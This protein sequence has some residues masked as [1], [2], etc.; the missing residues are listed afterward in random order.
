MIQ[1][2]VRWL[3][4]Q[5]I[6]E[7]EGHCEQGLNSSTQLI[8]QIYPRFRVLS[9]QHFNNGII[10]LFSLLLA[11]LKEAGLFSIFPNTRIKVTQPVVYLKTKLMCLHLCEVMT[12]CYSV[13]YNHLEMQCQVGNW[14][15]SKNV[16]LLESNANSTHYSTI[17]EKRDNQ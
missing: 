13:N 3:P 14:F 1:E 15:E 4:L 8:I 12:S 6:S 17:L 5:N 2:Q 10:S 11:T 7:H 16:L 9:L